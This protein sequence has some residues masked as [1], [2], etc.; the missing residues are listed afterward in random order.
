MCLAV[1]GK[2]S[3]IAQY[4]SGMHTNEYRATVRQCPH[5]I[6]CV[7]QIG[8]DFTAKP[9]QRWDRNIFV[10]LH[11]WDIAGQDRFVNLTRSFY[12]YS[13]FI[14]QW[15]TIRNSHAALIVFDVTDQESF[16]GVLEWKRDVDSKIKL[17]NNRSIPT[18]LVANKVILFRTISYW[19]SVT[20]LTMWWQITNCLDLQQ[21]MDLL[22]LSWLLQSKI[23]DWK[24]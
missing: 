24:M 1:A 14:I 16:D 3:F 2:T 20:C 15:W 19:Y 9:I 6:K 13:A 12:K 8:C 10:L 11:I 18:V 17:S 22:E 21:I 23:L 7:F 5:F 4:A